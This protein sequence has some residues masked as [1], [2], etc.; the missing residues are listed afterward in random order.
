M[1][2]SLGC[3]ASALTRS[4]GVALMISLVFGVSMFL[5]S[6]LASANP[7]QVTWQTKALACFGLFEQMRDFSRG[8]VDTRP[9]VFCVTL[10]LF[11]LF[12]TL[13]IVESRR[14]K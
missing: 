10:T 12:L 13:R 9:V 7:A 8:V 6:V 2:V 3:C 11:F 14:W 5:L 4:Q 1:F